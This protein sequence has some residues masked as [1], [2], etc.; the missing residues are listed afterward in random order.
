MQTSSRTTTIIFN[1]FDLDSL[2]AAAIA[3]TQLIQTS[4]VSVY[5]DGQRIPTGQDNY[6]WIGVEPE[7]HKE[8]F[9]SQVADANHTFFNLAQTDSNVAYPEPKPSLRN[10]LTS[11]IHRDR[12]AMVEGT[13]AVLPTL[14]ERVAL[15]Y[16]FAEQIDETITPLS[17][18]GEAEV[19]QRALIRRLAHHV[20][21]FLTLEDLYGEA[22]HQGDVDMVAEALKFVYS[23]M[24]SALRCIRD[25]QTFI[26]REY[27]PEDAERFKVYLNS[28]KSKLRGNYIAQPAVHRKSGYSETVMFTSVSDEDYYWAVRLMR[29]VHHATVNVFYGVNGTV[30]AGS[31]L[32]I[33]DYRL[34]VNGRR[35][36]V[37]A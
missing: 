4:N 36:G 19:S 11:I 20:Q 5:D 7:T 24:V 15:V 18:D 26:V 6:V 31:G 10:R 13:N 33:Q 30:L 37:Y 21:Y 9:Y 23:A 34:N 25:G 1:R 32:N 22:R 17:V 8:S 14:L 29:K 12:Q 28:V 35:A 27:T 2:F 16:G 3:R